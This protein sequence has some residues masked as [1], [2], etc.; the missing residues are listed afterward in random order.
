MPGPQSRFIWSSGIAAVRDPNYSLKLLELMNGQPAAVG[1]ALGH[2]P[3]CHEACASC[4]KWGQG[5]RAKAICAEV[6][7]EIAWEGPIRSSG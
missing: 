7:V 6:L 3:A 5:D 1:L 4:A 2:S